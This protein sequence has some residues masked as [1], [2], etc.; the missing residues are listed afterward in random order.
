LSRELS[1]RNEVHIFTSLQ[2]GQERMESYGDIQIHRIGKARSFVQRGGILSRMEFGREC[3]REVAKLEPDVVEG[4]GFVSYLG[5]YRSGVMAD[6][7]KMVTVHEVWQGEWTRNMGLFNGAIGSVLEKAYLKNPFDRYIAVSEFTR[8]K[9]VGLG[10]D[11]HRIS[12]VKNGIDRKLFDSVPAEGKF[13]DPTIVTICRLV[14]YKKIDLLVRAVAALRSKYPSIRLKIVGKGPEEE[15]LRRL[16]G[17]LGVAGNVEFLGKVPLMED[18][19]RLMKR[20]HVF[21]LPSIVEGFGMVVVEAMAAGTPYVAS[22]ILPIR[23]ATG[24][25]LGGQL[26]DPLNLDDL[27]QRLDDTLEGEIVPDP[28]AEGLL[29]TYEWADLAR[30]YENEASLVV[31]SVSGARHGRTPFPERIASLNRR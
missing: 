17:D 16:A 9:L 30:Q 14:S 13:E 1:K 27:V 22:D 2:P 4:S 26:F 8:E 28:R 3:V 10:V 12:V 15:A 19:V 29:K 23:E 5:S 6:R 11:P 7:P 21:A 18:I 25:G 31:E 24:G 20:S